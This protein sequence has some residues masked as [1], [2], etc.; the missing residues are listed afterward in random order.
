MEALLNRPGFSTMCDHWKTEQSDDNVIKDVYDGNVWCE[1]KTYEGKPFL[2]D[3]FTYGLMLSIDWFRPCKHTEYSIGAIYLTV[4]NLPRAVRFRQENVLQIGLIPGP[5]EPKPDINS[6]LEP[7]MKELLKFWNGVH[8]QIH[9][10][11]DP[12]L[13]RCALLCVAC[14][15]PASRKVCG[16]LGHSAF[17]GYSKC[18]K[19]FPGSV[20]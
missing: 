18:L 4:M 19:E 10:I 14:D 13:V 5:K 11:N 16:F 9:V 20:G 15:I 3:S 2:L 7:L 17:R 8:L 12:V 6:H 1:F